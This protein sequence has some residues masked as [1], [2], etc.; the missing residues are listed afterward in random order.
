MGL[1]VY[2]ENSASPAEM[3]KITFNC[4]VKES[5]ENIFNVTVNKKENVLDLKDAIKEK[6][7][8]T[9][10][11]VDTIGITV[12]FVEI[13]Q[14]DKRLEQLK[15]EDKSVVDV[16]SGEKETCEAKQVLLP[17]EH[18][19]KDFRNAGDSKFIHVIVQGI[20]KW[21]STCD[22]SF[23]DNDLLAYH[24]FDYNH[25]IHSGGISKP[26]KK[27]AKGRKREDEIDDDDDEDEEDEELSND[28]NL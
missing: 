1:H 3:T 16:F 25:I 2:E 23:R 11:K 10:R 4:I 20:E 22:I 21:C 5:P 8:D 17:V 15:E 19:L 28:M 7:L 13:E 24:E 6:L 14:D 27:R 12:W 9:F 18:F 26:V